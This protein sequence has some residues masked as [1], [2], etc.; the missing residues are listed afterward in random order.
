[1]S[2]SLVEHNTFA[3]NLNDTDYAVLI[4]D[5]FNII[6]FVNQSFCDL[7]EIPL[8]STDLTGNSSKF[9]FKAIQNLLSEKC[10]SFFNSFTESS[11]NCFEKEMTTVLSLK[12]GMEYLLD[13]NPTFQNGLIS[14]QVWVFRREQIS[15]ISQQV[16]DKGKDFNDLKS[17]FIGMVSHEFRTP[18]AAISS[19]IE[20]IEM[21]ENLNLSNSKVKVAEH[22]SKISLQLNRMTELLDDVLLLNDIQNS[23][24]NYSPIEFDLLELIYELKDEYAYCDFDIF[25]QNSGNKVLL[26]ADRNLIKIVMLNLFSNAIKYSINNRI[27]DINLASNE[28]GIKLSIKDYGIGIPANDQSKLFQ[29]FYRASNVNNIP[30]SGLGLVI[31]KHL[32][33][34]HNA[35]IDFKS[36]ENRGSEFILHFPKK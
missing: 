6:Q 11:I 30:G 12:N 16:D 25:I 34:L 14:G 32:L 35:N 5:E 23:N 21:V 20:I 36:V 3:L 2:S 26:N 4:E 24:I 7:F 31:I 15:A 8:K 33:D 13:I 10:I 27:L 19:S 1:M 18:L 29:T 28:L 22:T 9:I 17:K